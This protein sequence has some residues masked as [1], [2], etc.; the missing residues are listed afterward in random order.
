MTLQNWRRKRGV[1]LTIKGLQKIKEAKHQSEAKENF[2]NRYTLEEMSARSGLYSGTISK[3]L[4]REGGVDKQTIE[5]LFSAFSL[6]IDKSDYSS[7][8][9][10]LDWG[11]AIFTSVFY[12]RREELSTLEQW[13]LDEDCRLVTLLGIGGIGKTALSVKFAQQIQENFE[14]VIWRSLREAPPVKI[15][16]SN[17]IQFLSDEQETEANLPESF[18]ERLSRLLDYLQNN[19]CLLILDNAESILR[20]GSRA[21][22]YREGYEEY[23]ELVRR[24][25]E[26]THQSCLM[27]TS[28]EKP[29]E[30]ALLEG[31]ALP[32]RSLALSGL[33]VAE[34]QEIL[35]LKGLSAAED[36]WKL[37]IERYAGN[38]LALKIVATTIQDIFD[39]NVTEFLQQD[40]AVFGDIRDVLEQQFERLSDLEKDIMYWLAI[41]Q[42]PITLKELRDDIISPIP[43]AKLLEAIESLGRRSLIEK[44]SPTLIE[45][46]KP[47]VEKTRSLFTL[48]PVVMEYVTTS[49]IEKACEEIVTENIDLFR[50]HALMKATGKDYV[51]D[52][53]IRLIVKPVIDGLLKTL[54]SKRKIDNELTRILVKLQ[55]TSPLEPGYTAGNILNLLSYLETDLSG[56]DFSYLTVWQA[57]LRSMNLHN[58]NFSHA[59]LNKC[60]FAETLG[61]IHSVAFS[62]DGKLL[63]TGDSYGELCL[64]Q[65]ADGK[66]LLICN[67]HKDWLWDVAFSPNGNMLASSS[68][69][70]TIKLWDVN[71]GYCLATL[72]GHSGG[73]W[74]VAFNGEGNI[75]ASASEDQTV[76][77]WDISTGQC[78]KTLHGN[79]SRIAS[80]TVSPDGQTLASG[81]HDQ[82]VK[83]WDINTGECL[84]ILQGHK[85][86]IWAVSFSPDGLTLASGSYDRTVKLWDIN[87][88]QCLKT[89]QEHTDCVYSVFFSPDGNTL[90]SSSDDKTVKLWDITTG[91]CRATLWGHSSRVWSVVFN[92][93]NWMVASGSSDQTVRL[94]DA[95]TG[96]CL[97]TLQGYS[98]GIWSVTFSVDGHTLVSGSGNKI[99]KLWD[100]NT[101]QCVK[102]LR[103]HNH[104]VTSVALSSNNSLLASGSEDR[105]IKLWNVTTGQCLTTLRGHSNWVTSVAFSPNCQIIASGSDDH[106]V[107][108]WDVNTGQCIQTLKGHLDKVW[109][110]AFNLNGQILASGSIDQ[111]IKLWDVTTGQCIQTLK[112]HD[113]LVWSIAYSADSSML[114]SASSDQTIKLWDVTTG[115]CIKTLKGHG[116]SVYSATF[117]PDNCIIASSSEDQTVKLWDLSTGKCLKSLEG[118]TQLVWSVVFSPN[119]QTLASGSQDDTIKIWDVKTSECIK[120]L[121][122]QRPYQGLN[123]TGVTG[124]TQAQ[125]TSLRNL[126][127]MVCDEN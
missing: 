92:P 94:W 125:K 69:D 103:G 4:N 119:G 37:M 72:Q 78:L 107:K 14:Y 62:P 68:K 95:R 50:R 26:A 59:D 12:G 65:V 100:A 39:G 122:N 113:D 51:K 108:L 104:R 67:G 22:V 35:K 84:K 83:L 63:A 21:G 10:R 120:T 9:N 11:E 66:Q 49:L 17:L 127:A 31:Q 45:T 82:T 41:N 70:Q 74:S 86:G 15:I 40:T 110:V 76:K 23:G 126:G 64:Y 18:N 98:S 56:Y 7:S 106:T 75:L 105:T 33:K 52:T 87:T 1:A 27:L 5:K 29:K 99:V 54:R 34:G 3:V 47:V 101:G 73:I 89:L 112:G 30:V 13:I 55:D 111:T 90:A 43:Q 8:N 6:K 19:R 124:I 61:G 97:K 79:N 36:Q 115:Q 118:H 44:A 77:L 42:E 58:V 88:G 16:I 96:Q 93:N 71:T 80:I 109:S 117:S 81:C 2:G 53:Q 48:Q 91:F 32:V 114:A 46:A 28:R 102:T 25:G 57:D 116:S 123:I 38:P 20:S 85:G 24:V 121:K 60:V